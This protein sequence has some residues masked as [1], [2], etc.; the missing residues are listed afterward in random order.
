M[1]ITYGL[2]GTKRE[3]TISSDTIGTGKVGAKS[4]ALRLHRPLFEEVN[5]T[6]SEPALFLIPYIS[7]TPSIFA[8]FLKRIGASY[9]KP[10]EA[11][12]AIDKTDFNVWEC[13]AI[14]E[15]LAP[16]VRQ[17]I[18]V[19]SDESTASGVG[20]WHSDFMFVGKRTKS[21]RQAIKIVKAILK[22]DFSKDVLAFKKRTG[23]QLDENPGVF[24]MPVIGSTIQKD[25]RTAFGTLYHI[26]MITRFAGDDTLVTIG[27][28]MG[29]ANHKGANSLLLSTM[30]AQD[31][32]PSKFL[33]NI[34]SSRFL[35]HGQLKHPNEIGDLAAGI[36]RE[37]YEMSDRYYTVVIPNLKEYVAELIRKQKTSLY[38]EL[39]YSSFGWGVIQSAEINL[40]EVTKACSK[41]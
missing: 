23:L 3:L 29:G 20:L 32:H 31:L 4:C 13:A 14:S 26:N 2:P 18:A 9:E 22:Y 38:L 17:N 24:V 35:E 21:M 36:Y 28:G 1:K 16:F 40:G 41:L 27:V 37:T 10:Q 39:G 19:R 6:I 5:A 15:L 30:T 34:E 12:A 11:I 25:G 7:I 33:G 8:E